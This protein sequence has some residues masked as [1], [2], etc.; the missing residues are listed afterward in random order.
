MKYAII[1]VG[2][3]GSL[4]AG[5]LNRAGAEV[6]C[7]DPYKAHM[8]AIRE[9]GLAIDWNHEHTEHY[10]GIH[11][12]TD[13]ADVGPADV[14]IIMVN[15][16]F[17]RD[18]MKSALLMK[19]EDTLFYS[20][21][22]GIGNVDIMMEYGIDEGHILH[23]VVPYGGSVV[24]PGE[25]FATVSPKAAMDFGPVNHVIT[26]TIERIAKDFEAGGLVV[27]LVPA[28][29][30]KIW[31]KLVM[32]SCGNAQCGLVRCNLGFWST[33]PFV[34]EY[35]IKTM[36]E[37]VAVAQAK[38]IDL[39]AEEFMP[40]FNRTLADMGAQANHLTSTA[41]DMKKKNP[42]EIEFLNGAI[43]R[44]GKKYGIE[45]PYNESIY[46]LTKA[47]EMAYDIEF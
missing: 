46:V 5:V 23:G 8:D 6:W 21:Q 3:M 43:V 40:V 24:A 31:F 7:V 4:L 28:V 22:N 32:N 39:T 33:E 38:G 9:K 34:R 41:Q 18:A 12:T 35:R 2:R 47:Y 37:I 1:G 11:A 13:P 19:K 36:K 27:H 26:P 42:T 45:T 14:I 16:N 15:G 25:I 20:M 29:E 44:E 17:T 10:T 30:K